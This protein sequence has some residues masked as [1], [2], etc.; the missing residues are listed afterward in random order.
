MG[1]SQSALNSDLPTLNTKIDFR[2]KSIVLHSF[3]LFIQLKA[4]IT[5]GV[6]SP[7]P[8]SAFPHIKKK[9]KY[10]FSKT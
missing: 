9:A 1:G 3:N 2:K 8:F 4:K 6:Q 10:L 7:K 5:M